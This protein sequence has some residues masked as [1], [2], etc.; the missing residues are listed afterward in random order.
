MSASATA[1][2]LPA[3]GV[4]R[5]EGPDAESFLQGLFTQDVARATPGAPAHAALLTPQGKYLADAFLFR[6]SPE[7][8][9]LDTA[10]PGALARRLSMYKLRAKVAVTDVSADWIVLALPEGAVAPDDALTGPDPRLPALPARALAS[11][12]SAPEV[13]DGSEAF[14]R[15]CLSL[16]VP[17]LARDLGL[18]KDFALEGLLDE[19]NGVDF[20][21]GCYVGQEMTSRMK[22]RT[23]VRTKLCR[24]RLAGPAPE[25]DAAIVADGWEVG[26]L[27]F[28]LDGLGMALLRFDRVRAA[29]DKGQ[30][31]MAG[32][33]RVTPDPPDW[34]VQP[35]FSPSAP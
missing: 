1:W 12:G 34:L 19:L 23:N 15:L 14:A 9:L 32:E 31:L 3:R 35:E 27:R 29:L 4:V 22:R 25:A 11:A 26:R 8:F 5:V 33:T 18:E 28:A 24:V 17:D 6:P 16:G 7:L 10:T 30:P 20:H 21:K 2:R 13:P